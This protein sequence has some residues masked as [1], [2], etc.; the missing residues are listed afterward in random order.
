MYN[1][2]N[3]KVKHLLF[4]FDQRQ[5]EKLVDDL[6]AESNTTNMW[7]KFKRLRNSLE[8]PVPKRPLQ[9]SAT[10]KT[11]NPVEKAE[12]FTKR[13]EEVHQVKNRLD[14]DDDW[15]TYVEGFVS[16]NPHKFKPLASPLP[17][18][19]DDSIFLAYITP[20]L[21]REKLNAVRLHSSPGEDKISYDLLRRCPDDVLLKICD[22]FN[23][24]LL[25]G[26]FP[27]AGSMQR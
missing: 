4:E 7:K 3:K 24:C 14:F 19:D 6:Q 15:K 11:T 5:M 25:I 20:A 16:S 12:I 9:K 26:F 21:F 8:D 13:L 23:F 17:E 2:V 18:I 27:L 22:I 10:E 1:S